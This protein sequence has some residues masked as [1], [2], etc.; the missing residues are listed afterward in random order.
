ME[1]LYLQGCW[2]LVIVLLFIVNIDSS[3]TIERP[4]G[5]SLKLIHKYSSKESPM[6]QANLT[7]QERYDLMINLS[8]KRSFRLASKSLYHTSKHTNGTQI[9]PDYATPPV[10]TEKDSIFVVAIGVG[11]PPVPFHLDLDTG[12][13]LSW[14]Q[15][16]GCLKCFDIKNGPF[17]YFHS[18]TFEWVHCDHP[19]CIPRK[20]SAEQKCEYQFKYLDGDMT[21]GILSK[22]NFFTYSKFT[23][24]E[25]SI[26]N[27]YFGCGLENIIDWGANNG[28]L[29]DIAGIFGMEEIP[30]SF[31]RFGED[32]IPRGTALQTTPLSADGH[33]YVNLIDISFQGVR[34]GIPPDSFQRKPDGSGGLILDTGSTLTYLYRIAYNRIEA[35]IGQ[36]LLNNNLRQLGEYCYSL[37]KG[38]KNFPTVTFHFDRAD[39]NPWP[40]GIFEMFDDHFCL[41]IRPADDGFAI[42]GSFIQTDHL[43]VQDISA[44]QLHFTRTDCSID[45][46]L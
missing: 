18:S 31:L 30:I 14:I 36:F 34:L 1:H 25:V 9:H 5:F 40:T 4:K 13:Y 16:S 33:Y 24:E 6:Y 35:R 2:V 12:S 26:P 23:D 10:S 41:N 46:D 32:A 39:F 8:H 22:D 45:T 3:A 15:C 11:T 7:D 17:E 28:P 21:S 37:P 38:F 42:L 44:G 27:M 43:F 19:L 20:C 29:N